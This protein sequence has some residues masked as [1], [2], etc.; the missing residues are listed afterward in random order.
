VEKRVD[1]V[2][3][4]LNDLKSFPNSVQQRFGFELYQVQLGD[5]PKSA[6]P[7][8][9]KDLSGVFELRDNFKGNTYRGVY[10]AKLEDRIYVLHCFQKK[11]KSGIATPKKDM[12][13]IKSRLSLAIE[14]SKGVSK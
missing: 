8:K 2:G 5:T 7:L 13:L 11:S 1:W 6:K 12:E 9:G 4:S 3:S 10:I 14:D